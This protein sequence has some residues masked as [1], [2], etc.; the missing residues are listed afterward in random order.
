M[1]YLTILDTQIN[2][3]ETRLAALRTARAVVAELAETR[4]EVYSGTTEKKPRKDRAVGKAYTTKSGIIRNP[5]AALRAR[6]YIIDFLQGQSEPIKASLISQMLNTHNIKDTTM[7]GVLKT[8]RDEGVVKW[9][10]D[11]RLYSIV[12]MMQHGKAAAS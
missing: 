5:G 2:E 6:G 10:T 9:D 1:N 7:W 4:A 12:P 3:L 11:T 8:L